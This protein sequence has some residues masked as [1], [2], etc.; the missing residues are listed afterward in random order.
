M[1]DCWEYRPAARAELERLWEK[2]ILRHPG[3]GRWARW[4]D[5]FIAG[6]ERGAMLTFAAVHSGEPV[7]EG[8]LLFSSSLPAVSG[9]TELADGV[10]T[11]NINA[12]RI[13]KAYE[14]QGHIS[15]LVRAMEA[16]ARQ[17]GIERI[18]IGVE[19]RETRNLAIYL[20]WGFDTLIT[21]EIDGGELILYYGKPL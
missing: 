8:T 19:A 3:D 18:T 13:E 11:T 5:E 2:N 10:R 20:H 17:R 9:R 6:N 14:G 15:R 7:G 21:H 16:E 1:H 4:R 12:L